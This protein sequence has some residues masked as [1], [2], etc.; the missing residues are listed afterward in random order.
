[1]ANSAFVERVRKRGFEVLYMTE[2]IDEYC[3]QQLKEFDGKSLVSVTKEG[4]ELP[5]D[6][7]EKKK[8]EEDKAKFESLCKL[9]KEILDKKVEKVSELINLF[10]WFVLPKFSLHI[11]A[12]RFFF[13]FKFT[14]AVDSVVFGN[15]CPN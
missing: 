6:E 9:M 10:F 11:A 7:E 4:L 14:T 1:M 12:F 13:F 15:R 3:V 8:M 2:P 5:E